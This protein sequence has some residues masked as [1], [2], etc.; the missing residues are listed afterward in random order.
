MKRTPLRALAA[1]TIIGLG[2]SL[3]ACAGGSPAGSD[4]VRADAEY[5]GPKVEITFWNGWTGGAAPVLVP[6]LI[7]EFNDSHDNIVVKDNA[8]EWANI[9]SKMPLAIK[10]GKGPDVAVLHGDDVATYAAQGLLLKTDEV[11]DALGYAE[12]NFPEGL[13]AAGNYKDAQYGVP[14]SVTPL[15]FYINKDVLK[16]A[17]IDPE[18]VPTDQ[19]SYLEVLEALK[20]K[21]IQGEW[22]DGY[23]FTGTFEFQSLLWQFGGDLYNEDV[24][25]ATFNSEAGVKALTWMKELID[26]GYSPKD[27]A[28]DGNINALIGGKTAFNWNGVWQTTNEALQATDWTAVPVPQIGTEKAVWSSST[29][30][31]FP[32]NK[33]QDADKSA[34]AAT[35]VKW[36]NDNSADWASTGELPAQNDVREDPALLETYPALAPF[37]EELEY[38]HF[39]TVSPGI[40]NAM[41]QVTVG[42]NEALLGKKSVKD[43]LD[44]A[45]AKATA[46][47]KQNKAQYGD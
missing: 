40:T 30:W 27:V 9:A 4:S 26:K 3:V 24:T 8:L 11:V 31:V 42:V 38:A 35:F 33:G 28:Q 7:K 45:A 47:L 14:W 15:G 12:D 13:M 1:A 2:M 17:G 46:L 37:L 29:H 32:A 19:E 10:A 39:E 18:T 34:A 21:G 23:V 44:D 25:E 22:V 6:K 36:M 5:D 43:A 16:E 20:A 41:A